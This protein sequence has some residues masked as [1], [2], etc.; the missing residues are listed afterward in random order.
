MGGTSY[1]PYKKSNLQYF[2]KI[3]EKMRIYAKMEENRG[4]DKLLRR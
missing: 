3:K 1:Y 2:I 4:I